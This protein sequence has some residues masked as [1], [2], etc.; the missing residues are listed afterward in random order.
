[1]S[2]SKR[3]AKKSFLV[4][5]V[6]TL[7]ALS[8]LIIP[9]PSENAIIVLSS[10]G[11]TIALIAL[12]TGCVYAW[13]A[14]REKDIEKGDALAKWTYTDDEWAKF[15]AIEAVANASIKKTMLKIMIGFCV[16]FGVGFFVM[17]PDGGKYV[18]M[19]MGGLAVLLTIVAFASIHNDK[20]R[21]QTKSEAL[22]AKDGL[23]FGQQFVSWTILGS[24][25]D[26]ITYH[27]TLDPGI[28]DFQYSMPNVRTGMRQ[29]Y[30]VRIPVP[31][32]QRASV[33]MLA[34]KLQKPLTRT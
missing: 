21:L 2:Y 32:S 12:I 16:L 31:A 3:I 7:I 13:M 28:L 22:I 4:A 10:V 15:I 33:E 34:G 1:M 8:P 20:K 18:A 14:T 26:N 17:D 5:L 9:L 23:M 24:S 30:N 19:V 25:L 27:E 6:C 11:G 29:S